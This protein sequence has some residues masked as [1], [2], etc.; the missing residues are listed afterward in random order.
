MYKNDI[1]LSIRNKINRAKD[2]EKVLK[3]LSKKYEIK[4]TE[5]ID[6]Y[7]NILIKHEQGNLWLLFKP[8]NE[9]LEDGFKQEILCMEY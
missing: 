3:N 6:K 2:I 4:R 1:G 8:K 5:D 7:I 9:T